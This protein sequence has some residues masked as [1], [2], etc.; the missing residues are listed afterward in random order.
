MDLK[1]PELRESHRKQGGGEIDLANA[2]KVVMEKEVVIKC[3]NCDED[4]RI[5]I[6]NIHELY[7]IYVFLSY[8]VT[9]F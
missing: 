4:L 2:I 1:L 6:H 9:V 3:P 5:E 7:L 8:F